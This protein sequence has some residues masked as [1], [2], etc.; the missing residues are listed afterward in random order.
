[1]HAIMESEDGS[2]IFAIGEFDVLTSSDLVEAIAEHRG[3]AARTLLD[4]SRVTFLD[5]AG[6]GAL[7]RSKARHAADLVIH[8]P[9]AIVESVLRITGLNELLLD[10][11]PRA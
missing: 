11:P 2:T 6:I 8:S 10:D 1:M 9:S 4:L 5:S 3:R 7:V